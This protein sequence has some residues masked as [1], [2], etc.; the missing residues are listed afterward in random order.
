MDPIEKRRIRNR[1]T[2]FIVIREKLYKKSLHER[3]LYESA[4][5]KKKESS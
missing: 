3:S 5:P 2:H 1:S 4:Y